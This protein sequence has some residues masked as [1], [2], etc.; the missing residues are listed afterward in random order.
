VPIVRDGSKPF[1]LSAAGRERI[2]VALL[3]AV[4]M[5]PVAAF[6][7][8]DGDEGFYLM[9]ARLIAEGKRPYADFFICAMPLLSYVHGAV[10]TV[11]GAGWYAPRFVSCALAIGIGLLVFDYASF[12]TG[13]RS[14]AWLA[15]LLYLTSGMVLGW[16]TIVK[17]YGLAMLFLLAGLL[18]LEK[19][20]R[21]SSL[22]AGVL[23][24]LA[25]AT[26]L[27]LVVVFACAA[28]YLL[29]LELSW[30][31]RLREAAL[32]AGGAVL[33]AIPL[34]PSALADWQA[35][36]FGTFRFHRVR[37]YGQS[38]FIG[39]FEQKWTILTSVLPLH[40]VDGA[41]SVQLAVLLVFAVAALV[42]RKTAQNSL[43]GYAWIMLFVTSLLPTPSFTQ[44]F[45]MLVPFAIIET[46]RFLST[47]ELS[48]LTSLAIPAGVLYVLMGAGDAYRFTVDGAGVPGVTGSQPAE[49]WRIGNVQLLS[50]AIDSQGAN[51]GAS[52][53]PGYFVT[54]RTPIVPK[55]A[56]DFG[57]RAAEHL[58]PEERERFHIITVPEILRM[59]R[60]HEP[61]VF[62]AG[63]WAPREAYLLEPNGYQLVALVGT[64]GVFSHSGAQPA[65][66]PRE[67]S[68]KFLGPWAGP[69][70]RQTSPPER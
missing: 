68:L 50:S 20:K 52:W 39:D 31:Q 57:I 28:I 65:R 62:V 16:F 11:L 29:R 55:M 58:S 42:S 61:R 63:N 1:S 56:N 14:M 10:F 43:A 64:A 6:R 37:V 15:V 22:F 54:T 21:F 7:L 5:V 36:T 2:A 32:L 18:V 49:N 33:G 34:L 40:G 8:I 60:K 23:I 3:L 12:V 51:L 27:Y 48:K 69:P 26:R 70:P 41:G 17:T 25:A 59:I 13:R 66:L 53:W 38:S 35:F 9:A 47:L 46:T 19:R 45:C 44:Y 4:V 67:P 24:A 30:R